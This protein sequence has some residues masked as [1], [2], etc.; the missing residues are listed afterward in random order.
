VGELPSRDEPHELE[1]TVREDGSWLVDGLLDI[2]K[3]KEIL[4]VD[5]LPDEESGRYHTVSGF[6][7]TQLGGIPA[8][9]EHF[10]WEGFRFEV[11]DMDGRRV[12]KVL[13]ASVQDS[14]E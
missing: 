14:K 1:V 8:T 7:M 5:A 9:G 13:I 3:L 4:E 6:M 2:D 12:D 10:E 11:M